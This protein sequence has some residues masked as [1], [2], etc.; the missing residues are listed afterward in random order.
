VL[1]HAVLASLQERA[2]RVRREEVYQLSVAGIA[3][4][5]VALGNVDQAWVETQVT[6]Y[7]R[8]V[9]KVT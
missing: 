5:P 1:R 2:I 8:S 9:V 3:S 7:V 6:S 4:A